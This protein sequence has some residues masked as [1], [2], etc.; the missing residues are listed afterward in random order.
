VADVL[1]KIAHRHLPVGVPVTH[2]APDGPHCPWCK[3]TL[4]SISHLFQQCPIAN[5][6]WSVT[7]SMAQILTPSNTNFP[8]IYLI[9]TRNKFK[10]R[11][12]RL[13]QSA[14]IQ[15]IWLA[16]TKWAFG[17]EPLLNREQVLNLLLS[18]VLKYRNSDL[19][20][21]PNCPWPHYSRFQHL[22]PQRGN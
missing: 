10:Q 14:A 20:S 3:G 1:W 17:H 18:L 15:A 8:F 13:L 19:Y 5:A 22:I 9:H 12:A 2:I 11:Y 16:Y 21:H 4:N 6:V 7:T